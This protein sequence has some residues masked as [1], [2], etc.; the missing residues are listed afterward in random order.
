ML[1]MNNAPGIFPDDEDADLQDYLCLHAKASHVLELSRETFN[2]INDKYS[3]AQLEQ[4]DEIMRGIIAHIHSLNVP[5]ELTET[6][7]AALM[8]SSA[9]ALTKHTAE[10]IKKLQ[11]DN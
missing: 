5:Q 9:E 10:A 1:S 2:T 4:A 6:L 8:V 3:E 11:D 7:R